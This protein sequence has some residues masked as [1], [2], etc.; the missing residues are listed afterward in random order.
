MIRIGVANIGILN[1][2]AEISTCEGP[3]RKPRSQ[4]RA[5]PFSGFSLILGAWSG[6]APTRAHR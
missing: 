2:V 3:D 5:S 1:F 6:N 4:P